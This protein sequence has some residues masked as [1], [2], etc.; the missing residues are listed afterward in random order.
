MHMKVTISITPRSG[1][2]KLTKKH[3][4]LKTNFK[5]KLK[6]KMQR[7]WPRKN[8]KKRRPIER[9]MLSYNKNKRD[10]MRRLWKDIS[11]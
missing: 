6:K 4:N 1:M 11:I 5:L 2:I 10:N 9:E 8:K 7:S 3:L